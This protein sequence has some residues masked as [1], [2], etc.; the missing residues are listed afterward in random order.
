MFAR[1]WLPDLVGLVLLLKHV[2]EVAA[3]AAETSTADVRCPV[4]FDGMLTNG[5]QCCLHIAAQALVSSP[6]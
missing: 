6:D 5:P 4:A 1:G 2:A 3:V